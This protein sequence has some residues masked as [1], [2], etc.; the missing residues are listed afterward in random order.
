[1]IEVSRR[2][3]EG[4]SLVIGAFGTL[5]MTFSILVALAMVSNASAQ[6]RLTEIMFNTIDTDSE[7]EYFEV[8]NISGAEIDFS[9]TPYV[10]D[11]NGNTPLSAANITQGV[12]PADGV[13]VM[14]S[15]DGLGSAS[16]DARFEGAWGSGINV[17]PVANF[18]GLN[19]G[20]D[21]V[22]LWSNFSLYDGGTGGSYQNAFV[23]FDYT[24]LASEGV[25]RS[26]YWNGSGDANDIGN[27]LGSI[28]GVAGAYE[29]DE[30]EFPPV[31]YRLNS[32]DVGSPGAVPAGTP[33][34]AADLIYTEIMY[35]PASNFSGENTFEWFEVYNNSG[36]TLDTTGWVFDDAFTDRD[37]TES[38]VEAGKTF[39][40]GEVAIF[41]NDDVVTEGQMQD[42][43]G[44]GNTYVAVSNWGSLFNGVE[45]ETISLWA[46]I[47]AYNTDSA[48]GAKDTA[49]SLG[50]VTY[51]NG[52]G[53]WPDSNTTDPDPTNPSSI[54]LTDLSASDQDGLNWDLSENMT[55][56][57]IVAGEMLAE[58]GQQ[59]PDHVGGDIGSPGF[60]PSPGV[61]NADFNGDNIV[62]IADYTVWRDN[63]GSAGPLGDADGM[64][65]VTITDYEIWKSQF[66][67][68]P[69]AS[70]SISSAQ[71]PEPAGACY[72]VL[73][74]V[75]AM[76]RYSPIG[77]R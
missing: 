70:G 13:A 14:V 77:Q 59:E 63:L 54:Y 9:Q 15:S 58:L 33:T 41:Y 10:F 60:R 57:A 44:A 29:S 2:L 71:V 68:N 53:I 34:A 40:D 22:A 72:L 7:W 48:G 45:G 61:E 1:M 31:G 6:L 11:D 46:S 17:I 65:G 55:D 66:G 38:N 35:N 49:N 56:G 52:D 39:N 43:W 27:W 4:H 73:G 75:S 28:E 47:A 26:I 36:G 62:N 21:S 25:S 64:N 18:P 8:E 76:L 24:A 74:L 23:N 16:A 42:A 3:S 37:L 50:S 12:I 32:D 5:R 20:G 51:S 69:N 19:Q 67:T 30:S